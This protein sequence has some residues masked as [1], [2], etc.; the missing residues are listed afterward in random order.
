M[1][2]IL[3][4]HLYKPDG[5]QQWTCLDQSRTIAWSAVNDDYCDCPDGSDEPG[6][7]AC[8]GTFFYCENKG[9]RPAYIKSWS[10]NDG[11]CGKESCCDGSDESNGLTQCPNQCKAVAA[12]YAKELA[13]KK[14]FVSEGFAIKQRWIKEAE[15][16][17]AQWKL[18][19]TGYED[20]LVLK[21]GLLQRFQDEVT[22][23]EK[24]E[25]AQSGDKKPTSH[26]KSE[27]R[28]QQMAKLHDHIQ[29][30]REQVDTLVSILHDLKR[31]HNH[32]YHDMAVKA[33][34]SGYDE[35]LPGYDKL[36]EDLDQEPLPEEDD[37]D[38]DDA[39]QEDVPESEGNPPPIS[40]SFWDSV[41][42]RLE[43][44]LPKRQESQN[45]AGFYFMGEN[46]KQRPRNEQHSLFFFFSLVLVALQS[47][48]QQRDAIQSEINSLESNIKDVKG[49]IKADYGP[50]KEWL[51]L[52]DTCV[53]KDDGEYIYS[54]CILGRASQRSH[55]DS[56]NVHLGDFDG[57]VGGE[58]AKA[59][60]EH[61]HL[62]GTR[63]WNGPERSVKAIFECGSETEI[64]DV[65]EPEKCEYHFRVR[66][67]AVCPSPESLDPPK[68]HVHEEL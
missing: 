41:T 44:W 6:T 21:R 19:R 59:Y 52:K 55:K 66:S 11:V 14:K 26:H 32:N 1:P 17:I 36:Y 61:T 43:K 2:I 45:G 57:Y 31:D 23:L 28:K 58:G 35:F 27:A 47:A 33:A 18:E 38:Q 65:M 60:L 16:K 37:L 67:P 48:R 22:L 49:K 53:E 5:Q 39:D 8:P 68:A 3:G 7:S 13:E 30:L 9:H 42:S 51:Q 25:Q 50:E 56:S 54:L 40:A 24:E 20:D 63:C 64:L 4:Q 15:E 29:Q 10:V 34:I 12:V 62:H 46:R